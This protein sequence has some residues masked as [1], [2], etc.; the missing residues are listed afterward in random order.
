MNT[1]QILVGIGVIVA[2]LASFDATT[3]NTYQAIVGAAVVAIGE[4][5]VK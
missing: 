4:W 3:V 2:A 1:K 5:V